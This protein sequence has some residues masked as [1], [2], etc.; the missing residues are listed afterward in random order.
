[1]REPHGQAAPQ[2]TEPVDWGEFDQQVRVTTDRLRSMPVS[3]LDDGA[4]RACRAVFAEIVRRTS[5]TPPVVVSGLPAS[6][7]EVPVSALADQLAVLA[8]EFRHAPRA[9]VHGEHQDAGYGDQQA[10]TACVADV[11]SLASALRE[12]RLERLR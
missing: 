3:R 2:P 9:D 8:G 11:E 4:I 10:Q 1:M 7:P 12:L 6:L 5:T